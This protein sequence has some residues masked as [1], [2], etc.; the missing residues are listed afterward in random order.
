MAKKWRE[1]AE[2]VCKSITTTIW[3]CGH[4]LP[5][6]RSYF[7]S[8]LLFLLRVGGELLLADLHHLGGVGHHG[9]GER[10]CARLQVGEVELA[11]GDLGAQ[12]VGV[13]AGRVRVQL[14]LRN[15]HH[16]QPPVAH[17]DIAGEVQVVDGGRADQVLVEAG[18]GHDG[19]SQVQPLQGHGRLL[20]CLTL[21]RVLLEVGHQAVLAEAENLKAELA[22]RLPA[23]AKND[24]ATKQVHALDAGGAL[25]HGA[26][27]GVAVDL[28]HAIAHN[29]AVATP[30]LHGQ[31]GSLETGLGEE[32]LEDRRLQ[33]EVVVHL[34]DIRRGLGCQH[35]VRDQRR[36]VEHAAAALGKGLGGEDHA[37]HVRVP[38]DAV[39]DSVLVLDTAGRAHRAA[40]QRV[41]HR[42]LVGQLGG[43]HALDGRA[44]ARSVH[45][46]EHVAQA[47]VLLADEEAGGLVEEHDG[48]GGG[49]DAHLVLDVAAADVLL[50]VERAVGLGQELRHDEE[51]DAAGALGGAGGAGQHNVDNVVGQVVLAGRDE[52]L[53]AGDLV[54]A[55]GLLDGLGLDLAQVGAALRLGQAH[56]AEPLARGQLGQVVLLLLLRGVQGE[57]VH[58]ADREARV[59]AEAPVGRGDNL[60]LDQ[61]ERQRQTLAAIL[62]RD[63]EALPAA[64]GVGAV[65]LLEALWCGDGGGLRVVLAALGVARCVER[66]QDLLAELGALLGD[67]GDELLVDLLLAEA[68]VVA[69]GVQ[70]VVEHKLDVA[71]RRL[72]DLCRS[73]AN[74][75]L[76]ARGRRRSSSRGHGPAE[77]S[78]AHGRVHGSKGRG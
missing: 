58:A 35:V 23:A 67:V 49:L 33:A 60:R 2:N 5:R 16:P 1:C 45:E 12:V 71:A 26:D 73:D 77:G 72:E 30:D 29:V 52:D 32:A 34:G 47:V 9:L 69:L 41:R 61:A 7:F 37:A 46:G 54:R 17:G 21:V 19:S 10:L 18:A 40:L 25:V 4:V 66:G 78:G 36:V 65:G 64:L 31:G 57:G 14:L 38:E 43:G 59:H 42:V 63:G 27:A 56:G 74:V 75:Q 13:R 22:Q 55:V 50:L 48:G 6:S 8:F 51:R 39:G 76:A 28:L 53:L 11:G 68:L 20:Q 44:D 62:G 70:D 3:R 24:L 15:V